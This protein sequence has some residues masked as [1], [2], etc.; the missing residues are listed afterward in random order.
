MKC[1]FE[2]EVVRGVHDDRWTESLRRHLLECDH[3]VA[4]ASVAPWMSRFGRISERE[5]LLPDPQ[6]V[7]RKARLLQPSSD[8]TQ[9]SRPMNVVQLVAY[10]FVAG[11]WTVLLTRKWPVVE[12]WLHGLTPVNLLENVAAGQSLSICFFAFLFVLASITVMLVMREE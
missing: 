8:V 3:C 9:V 2:P 12:S 1:R 4:A 5:H 11:G 10:L 7:W 6:I